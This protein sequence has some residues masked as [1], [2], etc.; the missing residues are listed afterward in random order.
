MYEKRLVEKVFYCE[1]KLKGLVM[2]VI[3]N[4]MII[5]F[6][7]YKYK[8]AAGN[9]IIM[10]PVFGREVLLNKVKARGYFL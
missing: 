4:N 8:D 2:P 5:G 3:L 1:E 10:C 6:G 9:M 7:C